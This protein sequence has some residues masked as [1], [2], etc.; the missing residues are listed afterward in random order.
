MSTVL[1][2][3]D[4][5]GLPKLTQEN[6]QQWKIRITSVL[7]AN[8]MYKIVDGASTIPIKTEDQP[9]WN[10]L[11]AEAQAALLMTI[12]DEV[13]NMVIACNTPDKVWKKLKTIFE[14]DSSE[15]QQYLW[16]QFYAVEVKD[17]ISPL[18]AMLK[19]Q[20]YATQL[21]TIGVMVE[22]AAI[23]ARVISSL[24]GERYRQFREAWRSLEISKQTTGVLLQRLK[25]WETEEIASLVSKGES[26][27]DFSEYKAFKSGQ[28]PTKKGKCF[29]CG[30]EGH[31]KSECQASQEEIVREQGQDNALQSEIWN[32]RDE[33]R[34]LC[35]RLNNLQ[36]PDTRTEETSRSFVAHAYTGM[37]VRRLMYDFVNDSG[38]D[39]H[40]T[41]SKHWFIKYTAY[42][43]PQ[44]F[45]VADGSYADI[46]GV[47]DIAVLALRDKRWEPIIVKDVNYIP[48]GKNLFSENVMIQKHQ[49]CVNKSSDGITFTDTRGRPHLHGIMS[50]DGLQVMCF[51]HLSKSEFNKVKQEYNNGQRVQAALTARSADQRKFRK[52]IVQSEYLHSGSRAME[53]N[54]KR[55]MTQYAGIRSNL[56]VPPH[57]RD[58]EQIQEQNNLE[59]LWRKEEK[60]LFDNQVLAEET[61]TDEELFQE[62][63]SHSQV[64]SNIVQV[65]GR[66]KNLKTWDNVKKSQCHSSETFT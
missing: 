56:Y 22:D 48:G 63:T 46:I 6:Y 7:K 13:I 66:N 50:D 11:Q 20:S 14:S 42:L 58:M 61:Y 19:I 54:K 3:I 33:I 29:K 18:Q 40:F 65:S 49:F 25:T 43:E 21:A 60:T 62:E 47:G 8:D 9:G 26:V 45:E 39:R 64:E 24:K 27:M 35:S 23:V 53:F 31:Y 57:K 36:L 4:L 59:G 52:E 44:Q 16:Q 41:G 17:E 5:S 10:K 15:T 38:A 55:K 28:T 34:S 12:S 30:E 2:K 1:R 37:T 32:L 51:K